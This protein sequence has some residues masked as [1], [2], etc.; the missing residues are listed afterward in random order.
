MGLV[1]PHLTTTSTRKRTTKTT[2]AQ[3]EELERRWRD[4]NQS[5]KSMGL[6]KETFEQFLDFIHGRVKKEKTSTGSSFIAAYKAPKAK[7]DA[8]KKQT[9]NAANNEVL[10]RLNDRIK[11]P[12]LESDARGACSSKPSPTYTGEKMIGIS[13]MA[14][15][16]AVPVFNEEAITDIARMRR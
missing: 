13:Q 8:G 1:G 14:K 2:K 9:R 6:P 4:R 10:Q 16:N 15:S 7:N 12:S 11:Y 3:Q 5:L